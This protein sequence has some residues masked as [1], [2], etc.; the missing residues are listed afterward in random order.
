VVLQLRPVRLA[1]A[2][3]STVQWRSRVKPLQAGLVTALAAVVVA[4][5]ILEVLVVTAQV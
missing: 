1:Q 3:Q 4:E 2:A 5:E